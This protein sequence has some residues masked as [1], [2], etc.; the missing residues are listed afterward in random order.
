V[1][2][3][4]TDLKTYR[5]SILANFV[6]VRLFSPDDFLKVKETLTRIGIPVERPGEPKTLYQTCHIFHKQGKYYVVAFKEMFILD[7]KA[8]PEDF[9]EN[10]RARRNR[11]VALL[12]SWKLVE[13]VS[14]IEKIQPQCAVR[15]IKIIP[16]KEKSE[17]E[18]IPKY[19]IGHIQ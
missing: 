19:T 17:W 18:L 8:S 15:S 6:E 5:E 7:G 16:F 11:I 1:G 4:M 3:V 9:S 14:P 10:D 12:V 13:L 2:V